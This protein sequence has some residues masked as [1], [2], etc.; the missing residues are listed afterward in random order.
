MVSHFAAVSLDV[1]LVT[2]PELNKEE[3]REE[4]KGAVCLDLCKKLQ[5]Y[6]RNLLLVIFLETEL[7]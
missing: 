6:L 3:Q 7:Y 2:E 1:M 5:I 4:N